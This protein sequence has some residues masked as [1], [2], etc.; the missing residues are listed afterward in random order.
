MGPVEP[1]ADEQAGSG[2]EPSTG[3]K[4]TDTGTGAASRRLFRIMDG[5]M[6][7]G[8]CN[9]LAAYFQVDVTVVRIAFVA[10][11]LLTKGL[12]IMAYVIMMFV[13]PEA[14][15]PE[16]RA[17]AGGTPFNAKEVIDQ[18]KKHYAEGTRQW[19][20]HW[21]QQNRHWRRQAWAWRGWPGVPAPGVAY[22]PP[23]AWLTVVLP[24]FVFVHLAIFLTAA[25]M[26]ISLVNTGAIFYWP[27]PPDIPVWAGALMLFVA[28]Q[29]VV[30]PVRAAYHWAWH[31]YTHAQPGWFAFWHAVVWMIGLFVVVWVAADHLPEIR[32]FAQRVPQLFREFAY[33]MRDFF[34]R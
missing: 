11:A 16:E 10:A 1:A 33:A 6:I 17:A 23:P 31:P 3:A 26:M 27:L 30:S 28:Y 29:I 34:T 4:T 7:A 2:G 21:R 8:V 13:V 5:A 18:A 19:R 22:A 14:S 24:L 9:G 32:E 20:R 15:T 25:A 12:G